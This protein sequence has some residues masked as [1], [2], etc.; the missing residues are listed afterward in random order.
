[1]KWFKFLPHCCCYCAAKSVPDSPR[2]VCVCVCVSGCNMSC[3]PWL[4]SQM[5]IKS[6]FFEL[7]WIK[8]RSIGTKEETEMRLIRVTHTVTLWVTCKCVTVILL[9]AA[10]LSCL[11][12]RLQQKLNHIKMKWVMN[13]H[14]T[15]LKFMTVVSLK[16]CIEPKLNQCHTG[17]D[18]IIA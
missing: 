13:W 12:S 15:A 8:M 16:R 4:K 7:N 3:C 14:F 5:E 1:M 6:L 11:F 18:L 17:N 9:T 10:E 2:C